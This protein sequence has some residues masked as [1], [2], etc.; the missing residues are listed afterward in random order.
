MNTDYKSTEQGLLN[1]LSVLNL[2][3]L[4]NGIGLIIDNSLIILFH[5]VDNN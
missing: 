4:V 1:S 3:K 5:R 2:Y